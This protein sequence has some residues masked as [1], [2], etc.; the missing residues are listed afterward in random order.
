MPGSTRQDPRETAE[1]QTLIPSHPSF[2]PGSRGSVADACRRLRRPE[3]DRHHA[4][5]WHARGSDFRCIRMDADRGLEPCCDA[6]ASELGGAAILGVAS[7]HGSCGRNPRLVGRQTIQ[8]LVWQPE[9]GRVS[10]PRP[11][12]GRW[13]ACQAQGG[14]GRRQSR[15]S[16]APHG[17][18]S[19]GASPDALLLPRP[20]PRGG[21]PASLAYRAAPRGVRTAVSAQP[22]STRIGGACV[23]PHGRAVASPATAAGVSGA[24]RSL[25]SKPRYAPYR[26][27]GRARPYRASRMMCPT[28]MEDAGM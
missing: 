13:L 9:C 2:D 14:R 10:P 5:R 1:R 27:I 12:R 16:F 4:M 20:S 15:A 24:L 3:R 17:F 28:A 26:S 11:R 19:T 18:G 7:Q 8:A 25:P 23:R 22:Q 21:R 6:P